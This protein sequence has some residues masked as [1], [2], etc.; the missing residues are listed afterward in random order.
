MR[1]ASGEFLSTV[2]AGTTVPTAST[3]YPCVDRWFVYCTGANVTA[4]QVAGVGAIQNQLQITGAASVTAVGVGQ[5]I[6]QNNSF[7]LAV[8]PAIYLSI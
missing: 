2:V 4:A 5:R 1:F 6:E 7:E 3:G 8:V